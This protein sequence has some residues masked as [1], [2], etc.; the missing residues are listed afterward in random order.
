MHVPDSLSRDREDLFHSTRVENR[1]SIEKK[2]STDHACGA[3]KVASSRQ[4]AAEASPSFS[5]STALADGRRDPRRQRSFPMP[6]SANKRRCRS[7]ASIYTGRINRRR[8]ESRA[9]LGSQW[10]KDSARRG[11]SEAAPLLEHHE[12]SLCALICMR[13]DRR[14]SRVSTRA[15]TLERRGMP[16][17][18][19]NVRCRGGHQSGSTMYQF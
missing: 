2:G 13:C 3:N 17:S 5:S 6:P 9:R 15:I 4:S 11:P 16:V 7:H 19:P 14:I 8:R 18:K 1:P 10:D 12:C